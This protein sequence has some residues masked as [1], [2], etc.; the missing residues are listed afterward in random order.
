MA[1]A[2]TSALRADLAPVVT[3]GYR[4]GDVRHVFASP[5][6]AAAELGFTARMPFADGMLEFAR[7]PLRAPSPAADDGD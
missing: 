6:R 2:L 1:A 7:A 3:G 5:A 4:L